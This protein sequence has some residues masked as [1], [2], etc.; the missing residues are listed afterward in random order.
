MSED[1]KRK[2]A[3][4]ASQNKKLQQYRDPLVP[5]P[6]DGVAGN[7]G[8]DTLFVAIMFGVDENMDTDGYVLGIFET[9]QQGVDACIH[10]MG[11]LVGHP[12]TTNLVWDDN[13][14]E[15]WLGDHS[16]RWRVTAGP[17]LGSFPVT[18]GPSPSSVR[19]PRDY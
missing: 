4:E 15:Y 16:Y 12:P 11:R 3:E 13:E 2:R 8:D 18:G 14:W 1:G 17:S 10:D 6:A 5:S 9:G 7:K 19:A